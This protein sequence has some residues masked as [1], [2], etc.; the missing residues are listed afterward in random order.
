MRT[1]GLDPTPDV[2]ADL[3]SWLRPFIRFW[4]T[5]I[6]PTGFG[7]LRICCGLL[8]FYT[9]LMYSYDLFSYVGPNSWL[10]QPTQTWLRKETPVYEPPTNWTDLPQELPEK[11]GYV[12]SFFFHVHDPFW[13]VVFHIG[14]LAVMFLFTIGLWTRV[15]SV[16]TWLTAMCYI[17]SLSTS[18]FGMDTMVVIVLL[19]LIIGD[20]GAALSMDRWLERRRLRREQGPGADL[21]LK[22][23]WSVNL[24]VRLIQIHFCVIYL[25]SGASKLLGPSWWNGN[26]LWICIANPNFAPMRV[27]LYDQFLVFLCQHRWLWEIYMSSSTAFTLFTEISFAFLIWNKKLRPFMVCCSVMMHIGIG[28]LMGLVVFSL[29]ML[30][31]VLAFVPPDQI[32]FFLESLADWVLKRNRTKEARPTAAAKEQLV[33][34]RT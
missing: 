34:S 29:F 1:T 31:M 15:T 19:Y 17:H 18:Q 9:Y 20:G 12:W 21:A 30:T 32:R 26:A 25:V 7:F 22:P 16:L 8:V 2:A 10:D 11:G 28:L 6:D 23:S 4:F 24:A 3:P 13:V 33:L 5:P 14:A 27:G